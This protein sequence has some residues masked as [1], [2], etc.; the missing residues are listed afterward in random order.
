M[1]ARVHKHE[2]HEDRP[3]M[4]G[5]FEGRVALVTGG[6]RGIG[7]ATALQLARGGADVAIGYGRR[8]ETADAVAAEI[9]ALGR[10][11]LAGRCDVARQDQIVALI[12]DTRRELGP[13]DLLCHCGAIS[14]TAHHSELSFDRW[15]E[16]IDANLN[17]A[18]RVVFAV[19]DEMIARSFGRIVLFSSVAALRPRAMQ[20]HY[21]AAKAGV[22]ALARCCSDAFAPHGVRVNCIAPGLIETEMA[23]VLSDEQVGRIRSETP[24]GRLGRPEEIAELAC[25]LLSERSSFMTGQTIVSSGGRVTLP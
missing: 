22:I 19:K 5:E 8:R 18:F 3:T 21:S 15:F 2:K 7:R 14:N 10:Q 9:R 23:H 24:L 13:I 12:A 20:I 25:F 1:M 16:T 4:P 17:G 6:S 11:S